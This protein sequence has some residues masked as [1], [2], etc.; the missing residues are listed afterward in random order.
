[1]DLLD[2]Q[3]KGKM[4]ILDGSLQQSVALVYDYMKKSGK[5]PDDYWERLADQD[6][7]ISST[8]SYQSI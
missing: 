1:M 6:V 2:P 3:L 5:L 4:S 7:L 8:S